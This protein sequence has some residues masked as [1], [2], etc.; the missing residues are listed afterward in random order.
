[1]KT[2][3]LICASQQRNYKEANINLELKIQYLRFLNA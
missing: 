3:I 2:Q 1:M